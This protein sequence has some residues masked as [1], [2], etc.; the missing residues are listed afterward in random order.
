MCIKG[1]FGLLELTH[2]TLISGVFRPF[3]RLGPSYWI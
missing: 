2:L 1:D 3:Q